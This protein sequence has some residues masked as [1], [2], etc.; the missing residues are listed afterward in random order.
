MRH[1]KR[2]LQSF[3][4]VYDLA[5]EWY[6]WQKLPFVF[7]VWAVRNA[8]TAEKREELSSLIQMSLKKG[9]SDLQSISVA[10]A[11]RIGW[12]AGEATEYLEGFNYHLGERERQAIELFEGL[13]A[14]LSGEADQTTDST[15]HRQ[16]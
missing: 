5:T 7:A 4:L 2:G 6:D 12:T 14:M 15:N 8:L 3:E 10:H 11:K 16:N 1:Q 9:E 13:L